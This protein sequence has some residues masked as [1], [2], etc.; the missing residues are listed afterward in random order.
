[1]HL[2]SSGDRVNREQ[3][4]YAALIALADEQIVEVI[5]HLSSEGGNA[6]DLIEEL[7]EELMD[8]D[9]V[10]HLIAT[11]PYLNS[12]HLVNVIDLRDD[13]Y[14]ETWEM[15]EVEHGTPYPEAAIDPNTWNGDQI[16]LHSLL[17]A[18][19]IPT[20]MAVMLGFLWDAKR[21]PYPLALKLSAAFFLN[22]K[23]V[24][25]FLQ[26]LSEGSLIDSSSL[27]KA[28][29]RRP[30]MLALGTISFD[31]NYIDEL[32]VRDQSGNRTID[33]LDLSSQRI[34]EIAALYSVE[35][36]P[37]VWSGLQTILDQE[38]AH[39]GAAIDNAYK[40]TAEN[41][42]NDRFLQESRVAIIQTQI[43]FAELTAQLFSSLNK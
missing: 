42:T 33:W 35:L 40:I 22:P 12:F 26:S 41:A 21:N 38:L 7:S 15:S 37:E 29:R 17:L 24:D 1:M 8:S 36:T 16:T 6:A 39:V 11:T 25:F 14:T 27:A 2:T 23:A 30:D 20:V 43:R 13:I 10:A 19:P 31:P 28:V 18:L 32:F 4:F 3:L 9:L 5:E 34:H